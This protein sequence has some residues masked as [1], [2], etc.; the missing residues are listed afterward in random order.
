VTINNI[1]SSLLSF[2]YYDVDEDVDLFYCFPNC[3]GVWLWRGDNG[4]ILPNIIR[5]P[6]RGLVK[7]PNL[8]KLRIPSFTQLHQNTTIFCLIYTLSIQMNSN[9]EDNTL[10]GESPAVRKEVKQESNILKNIRIFNGTLK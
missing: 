6:S 9:A 10:I 5:Y 2:F 7:R 3:Y 4:R 8:Y 1:F